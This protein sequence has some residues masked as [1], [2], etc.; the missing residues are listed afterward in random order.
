MN[1]KIANHPFATQMPRARTTNIRY[2]MLTLLAIG[3]MINYLDR[4][5]LG[6]AAPAVSQ[7][8]RIDPVTMGVVFSAFSWT[9]VLAQV[10]GGIFLDRFGNRKTYFLALSIW[11]L[12]TMLHSASVGLKS[13]LVLRLGLGMSQAPCFPAN[14]RVVTTWFPQ[15]ERARA[16]ATFILGQYLGLAC[17]SPLLFWILDSFGWRTLF[18]L[19][20]LVGILFSIV[21]WALYRDPVLAKGVSQSELD[22]IVAG[23]GMG[24][25]GTER[26]QFTWANVGRLFRFRQI[27]GTIIGR[28][29]GNTVLVFFITWYPTYLATE[30]H[31]G[32]IKIGFSSAIPFIAAA[33]GV[34]FGGW[35]SDRCL[36]K[37]GSAN[38]ARK[39]PIITGLLMTTFIVG[40]NYVSSD[41]AVILF[42]AIAFFGQGMAGLSWALVSDVAPRK[43][44][45][46]TSSLIN[47]FTNLAGIITP[48]VI[49]YIISITGSFFHALTYIG[50]V[51]LVGVFSYIFILGDVKRIEFE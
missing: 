37:T 24:G 3:T 46:L 20:G 18:T 34:L 48:M 12:I 10:P 45:G 5:L 25:D 31:M 23:G 9:Y 36:K 17:F 7:E 35:V 4:T 50:L 22:Y 33:F 13:L 8:L 47:F 21:W 1:N 16:S 43:M 28:F 51:S 26:V 11:S 14:C 44:I 19:I 40:A 27:T 49:G 39:L 2:R 30:R 38:V 6:I 29:S 15:Q 41:W 42:M 32:W